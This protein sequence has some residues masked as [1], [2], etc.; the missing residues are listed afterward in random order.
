MDQFFN[1]QQ[2]QGWMM[3]PRVLAHLGAAA[4]FLDPRGGLGA[5]FQGALNGLMTG[6][7]M[8][9]R[10]ALMQMNQ[11]KMQR[12]MTARGMVEQIMQQHARPDGSFDHKGAI[13]AMMSSGM[14][15]MISH[16]KKLQAFLPQYKTK[17]ESVGEDGRPKAMWVD[18]YGEAKELPGN[19]WKAPIKVD[20]GG[21]TSMIDPG[22]L[23][24]LAKYRKTMSPDAAANLGQRQ[25]EFGIENSRNN[26][27]FALDYSPEFQ[28]QLS[29]SRAMATQ[30]G[31]NK[32]EA[33]S[34]FPKVIDQGNESIQLL[35]DLV[36]HPGFG[37]MVGKSNPIGEIAGFI[38]GTDARDFKARFDQVKGK[39][40]LEAFETLKGGGQI[41]EIEG[42][43]ATQAISRMER[44]QSEQEFVNAAREFQGIIR[45]GMGRAATKAGQPMPQQ[46]RKSFMSPD[47][48]SSFEN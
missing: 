32:A 26:A 42:V 16:V 47:G 29:G 37:I 44:A 1:Q 48:W 15:E 31:K 35:D 40:F 5:G 45:R 18:T 20:Q 27:R 22:T 6:N 28:G 33:I 12:D 19:V 7:E 3:N 2:N 14:P 11:M 41:T 30:Q 4:G 21:F 25:Y 9:N 13:N 8:Q 34:S 24:A 43:K 38:P 46:Q 36:N 23:Q 17:Y 39:Q 10:N